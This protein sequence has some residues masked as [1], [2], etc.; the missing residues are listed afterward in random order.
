MLM[1]SSLEENHEKGK[2]GGVSLDTCI[3]FVACGHPVSRLT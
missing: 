2:S 1:A 3:I